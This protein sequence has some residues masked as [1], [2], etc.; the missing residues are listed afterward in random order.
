MLSCHASQKL[1][2]WGH[3]VRFVPIA[4]VHIILQE[5]E[6]KEAMEE[7]RWYYQPIIALLLLLL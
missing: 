5:L 7:D 1:F 6:K 3:S 4:T 2:A